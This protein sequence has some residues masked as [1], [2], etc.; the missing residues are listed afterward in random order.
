MTFSR[1]TQEIR[2]KLPLSFRKSMHVYCTIKKLHVLDH[3]HYSV[4]LLHK[5]RKISVQQASS[6][7]CDWCPIKVICIMWCAWQEAPRLSNAWTRR[8]LDTILIKPDVTHNTCSPAVLYQS[9]KLHAQ[10][11]RVR[12]GSF[13]QW[14]EEFTPNHPNEHDIDYRNKV[15]DGPRWSLHNKHCFMAGTDYFL[16]VNNDCYITWT[17]LCKVPSMCRVTA[18]IAIGYRA[19]WQRPY[20]RNHQLVMNFTLRKLLPPATK[21]GQGYVFTGVCDSV[22]RGGGGYLTPPLG[23]DS[24]PR[25]DTPPPASML[26]D[27]VNARAVRILLECN[28]VGRMFAGLLTL[29]SFSPSWWGRRVLRDWKPALILCIRLLS[30]LFAISLRRRL[31]CSMLPFVDAGLLLPPVLVPVLEM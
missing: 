23:A 26:W 12:F 14:G 19:Y 24:P 29:L 10:P 2:R 28:L 11:R 30:L 16:F 13:T 15:T 9:F 3:E 20:I 18:N 6:L 27:T 4:T 17:V 31:S 22:N 21:L 25:A 5:H 1:T 7:H 8:S